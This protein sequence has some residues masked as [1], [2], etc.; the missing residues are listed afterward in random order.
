MKE[1]KEQLKAQ[2]EKDYP[3]DYKQTPLLHADLTKEKN[4]IVRRIKLHK[5]KA[6]K[7]QNFIRTTREELLEKR[8]AATM[9]L[10]IADYDGVASP[11]GLDRKSTMRKNTA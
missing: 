11:Q 2:V 7:L 8:R 5:M 9:A 6:T 3:D 10:R 1:F 4:A